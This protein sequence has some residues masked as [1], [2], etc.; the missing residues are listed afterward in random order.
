[1]E[2]NGLIGLK[3]AC[4]ELSI[5]VATGKNWLKLGKMLPS[6]VEGKTAYFTRAYLDQLKLELQSGQNRALKSRRNKKYVSGNSLYKAY[7]S[8]KSVNV[9]HVQKLLAIFSCQKIE[10]SNDIIKCVLAECAVCL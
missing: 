7:V 1:M 6:L 2:D 8:E 9:A 3:D 5:S 10:I 4:A